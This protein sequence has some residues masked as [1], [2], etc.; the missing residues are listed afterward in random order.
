MPLRFSPWDSRP[1]DILPNIP[2]FLESNLG[3]LSVSLDDDVVT[4]LPQKKVAVV[5]GGRGFVGRSV[6][7]EL[8]KS[9]KFD[10]IRVFDIGNPTPGDDP[11]VTWVKGDLLKMDEVLKVMEGVD[12]VIH[13]AAIIDMRSVKIIQDIRISA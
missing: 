11:N 10:E 13:L 12:S 5:T 4:Q 8:L 6:V 2:S 9:A 7:N 1:Y 3:P